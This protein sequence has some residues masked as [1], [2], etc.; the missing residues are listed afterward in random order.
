MI[1]L[2]QKPLFLLLLLISLPGCS[3]FAPVESRFTGHVPFA[4]KTI[5]KNLDAQLASRYAIK[6]P[7]DK[8]DPKAVM[9]SQI[10][11]MGTTPVNVNTLSQSC[12]LARQMT[13]EV[14]S[15]LMSFGY[16]YEEL[17]KGKA[18]RFDR[19]VGELNLTRNVKDLTNRFGQGEAIMTATYVISDKHVR[20]SFSLIHN[21]SNEV[22]AKASASIPITD[23]IISLLDESPVP[24]PGA[25]TPYN[26]PN[27]YIWMQ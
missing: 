3:V 14:S 12:P 27:T 17:R 18:I 10:M 24:L 4:A 26:V 25:R 13:E 6:D 9:R 8:R 22:L 23:D 16:R 2:L 15:R 19:T 11:I 20:F 5:A 1:S 7:E 21:G